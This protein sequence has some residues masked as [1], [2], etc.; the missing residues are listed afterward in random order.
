M[1]N[2]ASTQRTDSFESEGTQERKEKT[3]HTVL[4]ALSITQ[5]RENE[6]DAWARG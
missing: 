2:I 1:P 5:G 6:G 4:E 3:L